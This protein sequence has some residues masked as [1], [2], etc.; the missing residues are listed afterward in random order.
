VL[1]L[2]QDIAGDFCGIS[3]KASEKLSE[4]ERKDDIHLFKKSDELLGI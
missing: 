3:V 1:V 2:M 4:K